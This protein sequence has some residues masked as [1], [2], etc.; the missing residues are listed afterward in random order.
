MAYNKSEWNYL[1]S[2][3]VAYQ[4]ENDETPYTKQELI[5]LCKGNKETARRLFELLDWQSPSTLLDEWFRE[6]EIDE[7]YNFIKQEDEPEKCPVCGSDNIRRDY[8]FP[9]S[10]MC[11]KDC[12]SDFGIDGE[13]K[14]N[15]RTIDRPKEYREYS[16][17]EISANRIPKDFDEWQAAQV[18]P[19]Y[20][21]QDETWPSRRWNK[22]RTDY[23]DLSGAAENKFTLGPWS[24]DGL[25]VDSN[26][27]EICVMSAD[28]K[29]MD[30]NLI[31]YGECEANAR[32]IAAAP[33]LLEALKEA[34]SII[35]RLCEEF[36][37]VAKR[38]ASYTNGEAKRINA[39][40][41]SAT[42]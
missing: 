2:D 24:A 27:F 11:C 1:S 32:L 35:D 30:E 33:S 37:T 5:D 10:M 6:G 21:I 17:A 39:A 12:G 9:S 3:S 8:D 7:N 40:I 34:S 23:E 15:A 41:K 14:C 38:H 22:E 36:S 20:P 13:V 16:E 19:D 28:A 4:G 25:A 29:D 31:S 26:Q 18:D 42:I